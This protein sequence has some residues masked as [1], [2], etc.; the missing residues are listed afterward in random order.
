M[1]NHTVALVG[2]T[3]HLRPLHLMGR[4]LGDRL[5]KPAHRLIAP[6]LAAPDPVAQ[7]LAARRKTWEQI[8]ITLAELR[9]T[10]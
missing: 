8:E 7:H 10:A 5:F 4:I 9:K 6:G 1:A 3:R 2:S